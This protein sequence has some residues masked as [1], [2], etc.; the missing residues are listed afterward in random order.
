[1]PIDDLFTD[2]Q[3]PIGGNNPRLK[4]IHIAQV[5][6]LADELVDEYDNLKFREWY[7]GVIN[8]Y[9]I[10]KV[11]EWRGR[12]KEGNYPGKLFTSFVNQAGGYR[13]GK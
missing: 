12:A 8:E 13:R 1:M 2:Y 6:R 7:C 3:M 11:L 5:D 4:R 9:G 10:S